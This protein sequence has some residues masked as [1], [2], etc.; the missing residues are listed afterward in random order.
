[1]VYLSG[2]RRADSAR[3]MSFCQGF[4]SAPK[5]WEQESN[6]KLRAHVGRP[7]T[8]DTQFRPAVLQFDQQLATEPG[9]QLSH[10]IDVQQSRSMNADPVPRMQLFF[11]LRDGEVDNV[12]LAG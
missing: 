5:I 9:M 10:S 6:S 4:V 7:F 11:Q 3:W 12:M 1:M 2:I 8:R